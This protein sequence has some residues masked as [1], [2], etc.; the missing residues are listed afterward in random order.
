MRIFKWTTD[1]WCSEESPIVPVW[2][3]FSYLHVHFMHCKEVLFSIASV[4]GKPLRIDQATTSLA[5]PSIARVLVEYDVT[6]LLLP[7]LWVSVGD[8]GFWQSVI[9]EKIPLYCA[10]CKHLGHTIETCYMANPWLRPQQTRVENGKKS[11]VLPSNTPQLSDTPQPGPFI[12][13]Q[14]TDAGS[15][16]TNVLLMENRANVTNSTSVQEPI[17]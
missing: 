9:F 16:I 11:E 7:R 1:F 4:I 3:S 14:I 12:T 10:S 13:K 5:H 6:K 15:P 2:I 17:A 8:S